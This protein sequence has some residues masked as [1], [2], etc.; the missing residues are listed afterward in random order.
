MNYYVNMP[1]PD[2]DGHSLMRILKE[3]KFWNVHPFKSYPI[4]DSIS[5]ENKP[6]IATHEMVI[7]M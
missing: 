5:K 7:G 2:F 1:F 3:E 6:I 4:P